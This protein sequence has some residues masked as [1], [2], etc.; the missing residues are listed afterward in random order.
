MRAERKEPARRPLSPA[1]QIIPAEPPA[2]PA[3]HERKIAAYQQRL[4]EIQ[5]KKAEQLGMELPYVHVGNGAP[6][7]PVVEKGD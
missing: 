2:D 5:R 4:D 3:E 7:A 1:E 6:G